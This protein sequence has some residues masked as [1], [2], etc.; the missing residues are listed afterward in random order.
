[1]LKRE[2]RGDEAGKHTLS[3]IDRV[4]VQIDCQQGNEGCIQIEF[5][6]NSSFR[7]TNKREALPH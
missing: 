3:V 2:G 5:H 7:R 6:S 4:I 1:M